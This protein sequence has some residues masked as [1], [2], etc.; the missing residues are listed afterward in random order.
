MR[1]RLQAMFGKARRSEVVFLTTDRRLRAV[2]R[3]ASAW[4]MLAEMESARSRVRLRDGRIWDAGLCAG[5][6]NA[7]RAAADQVEEALID[8][9][10]PRERV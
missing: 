5:R 3:E 7:F 4:R 2:A 6:A 10:E 1:R 8:P 9:F